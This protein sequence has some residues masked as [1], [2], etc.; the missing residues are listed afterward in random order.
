MTSSLESIATLL[1]AFKAINTWATAYKYQKTE[2]LNVLG[3]AFA[4]MG[5]P[6]A[7][8]YWIGPGGNSETRSG[9]RDFV[10]RMRCVV[11]MDA[12]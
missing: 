11:R 3:L 1:I 2:K 4:T 12:L 9:A 8:T 5:Q 6:A 10:R 7:K